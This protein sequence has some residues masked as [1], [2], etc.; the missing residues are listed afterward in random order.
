[1]K[2]SHN[3]W[4]P[5]WYSKEQTEAWNAMPKGPMGWNAPFTEQYREQ[6]RAWW[7]VWGKKYP[8]PVMKQAYEEIDRQKEKGIS[9]AR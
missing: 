8:H 6:W 4:M 7:K 5:T 1:M 3:C 9:H 2:T